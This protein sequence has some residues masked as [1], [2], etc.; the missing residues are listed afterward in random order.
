MVSLGQG[1]GGT[2]PPMAPVPAVGLGVSEGALWG[3]GLWAPCLWGGEGALSSCA[4]QRCR[5][6]G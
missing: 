5:V 3:T 4:R 6:P 2:V 1:Q